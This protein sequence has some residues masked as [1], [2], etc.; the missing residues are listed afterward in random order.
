MKD[1]F[2]IDQLRCVR[3]SKQ[4]RQ[5]HDDIRRLF[6]DVANGSGKSSKEAK[7]A[8]KTLRAMDKVKCYLDN[9][10]YK[11]SPDYVEGEQVQASP[12]RLYGK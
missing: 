10:F 11:V 7:E 6:I 3:I 1:E 5:L 12:Y 8:Q 4:T 9:V 2:K